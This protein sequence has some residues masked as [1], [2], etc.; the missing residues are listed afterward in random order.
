M[1]RTKYFRGKEYTFFGRYGTKVKAQSAVKK[2]RN[3][4]KVARVDTVDQHNHDVF[5]R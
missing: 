2:L 5:I 1:A 3:M 4:G